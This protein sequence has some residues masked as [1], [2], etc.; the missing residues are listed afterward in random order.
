[1]PNI[2]ISP[3]PRK[4]RVRKPKLAAPE[5]PTLPSLFTLSSLTPGTPVSV[6][7][8]VFKVYGS[9]LPT[10]FLGIFTRV[11]M[12]SKDQYL[13]SIQSLRDGN[14]IPLTLY[15]SES[16]FRGNKY[17]GTRL[18]STHIQPLTGEAREDLLQHYR[19]SILLSGTS[20]QGSLP[21]ENGTDPEIFVTDSEGQVIP[22]WTFLPSKEKAPVESVDSSGDGTC[23]VYWD[24]FQAEASVSSSNC[25]SWVVDNTQCA[26]EKILLAARKV[27]PSAHLS[28]ES[29]LPVLDSDLTSAKPEHVGF[30]CH[31]SLNAYGSRGEDVGD[32]RSLPFRFAGGHLHWGGNFTS[33]GIPIERYIRALDA[34]IG[35][36]SVGM[37]ASLE[38]PLRRRF[39]GLAGEY[40]L[41]AHGIEYRVLSN[42][43]LCS[44]AIQFWYFDIGRSTLR[45]VAGSNDLLLL[46]QDFSRIQSIINECDVSGARKYVQENVDLYRALGN[47][48]YTTPQVTFLGLQLIFHGVE[49]VIEDP[50]DLVKNWRLGIPHNKGGSY[51]VGY[52]RQLPGWISHAEATNCT[53]ASLTKE[54]MKKHKISPTLE[55][56]ATA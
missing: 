53:M 27:N 49:S 1:M 24:G 34:T 36:A 20:F 50:R 9:T 52:N 41:P 55:R 23:S 21:M 43:W 26:L 12:Y 7:G 11:Q 46:S 45:L 6:D 14:F 39:Y 13:I 48:V 35:I 47:Q 29:A 28:L 16:D 33:T 54:Y 3:P 8:S 31:P 30:G 40:R 19:R 56:E 10:P 32:P 5:P 25:A 44:P 22:A 51:G 42:A 18:D 2:S 17:I 37:F 4:P 38:N 15:S